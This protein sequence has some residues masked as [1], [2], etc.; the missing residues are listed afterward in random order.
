MSLSGLFLITFLIVH[1]GINLTML[2]GADLFNAA[3]HFMETNM[4]IQAMQLV[5]AA[6]F[7]IHI[8]YGII[9]T[10]ENNRARGG[11]KY[12]V[13]KAAAHTPLNSRS[14]IYSGIIVLLFLILHMRDFFVPMKFS[15]VADNYELVAAKFSNPLFVVI[16]LIAFILL[17]IHLSHGFKSAFQSIGASHN[18]YT[19]IIKGL[20][21]LFFVAVTIGFATIAIVMYFRSLS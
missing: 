21:K 17:G 10:I 13:N 2:F 15:H 18:K 11:V 20:G 12:A 16:Y 8:F 5:L 19:P 6:G 7:I 4:L 1:L 14:M 3:S 9:L